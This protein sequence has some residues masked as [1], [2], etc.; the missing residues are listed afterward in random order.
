MP[1]RTTV[2]HIQRKNGRVVQDCDV[3][4]G[5]AMYRGGWELPQ[6]KWANP[7][8][9]GRDGSRREII[10]KY[11]KHITGNSVLMSRL[12]SLRGKTLG[13]W[14]KPEAC[15]GDVLVELVEGAATAASGHKR[16]RASIE[17]GS[18]EQIDGKPGTTKPPKDTEL[19]GV[20]DAIC[21]SDTEHKKRG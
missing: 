10:D 8:F 4:I 9:L 17:E 6:S 21:A 14:C 18:T 1:R 20:Q 7:Y 11:R 13:C 15:H 2:V 19:P 3:Y 16:S 12:E 5:R